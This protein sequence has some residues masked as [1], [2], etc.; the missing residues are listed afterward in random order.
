VATGSQTGIVLIMCGLLAGCA[1][2]P[3]LADYRRGKATLEQ[4]EMDGAACEMAGEQRR[5]MDGMGGLAGIAQYHGSFDRVFDACMR[6][7]GYRRR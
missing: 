6:S 1:M 7:K 4:F 2:G 3:D 5:S